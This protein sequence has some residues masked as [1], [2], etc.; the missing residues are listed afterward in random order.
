MVHVFAH[1]A[2]KVMYANVVALKEHGESDAETIVLVQMTE[3]SGDLCDQYCTANFWGPDCVNKPQTSTCQAPTGECKCHPG[4]FGLKCDKPCPAGNFGQDCKQTCGKCHPGYFG[5]KCDKPCPAGNFGQDCKQTCGVCSSDQICDP[6]I[7]CCNENDGYCGKAYAEQQA[8]VS[9]NNNKSKI[10]FGV[11]GLLLL[12][13]ILSGVVFYYRKKYQKEKD[14]ALPTVSFKSEPPTN[15]VFQNV[16]EPH[17][18]FQNPLY[19]RPIEPSEEEKEL[20]KLKIDGKKQMFDDQNSSNEYESI[21]DVSFNAGPSTSSP[22]T[23]PTPLPRTIAPSTLT[24]FDNPN[25]EDSCMQPLLLLI[26]E[27]DDDK[28]PFE[29]L[30]SSSSSLDGR[31]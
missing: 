29:T 5:L 26:D 11:I 18:E 8:L 14:P 10:G 22:L 21:R 28:I 20:E 16:I 19:S 12:V 1:L 9:N 27:N 30:S 17:R 2:L 4:Y 24:G 6:A 7:G 15:T 13:A 23:G 31:H 3:N 25:A